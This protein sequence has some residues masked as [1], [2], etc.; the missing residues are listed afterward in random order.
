MCYLLTATTPVKTSPESPTAVERPRTNTGSGQNPPTKV[1]SIWLEFYRMFFHTVFSR[2]KRVLNVMII[3]HWLLQLFDSIFFFYWFWTAVVWM[4]C[5]YVQNIYLQ[6]NI[7]SCV[8][9]YFC[10]ILGNMIYYLLRR[11]YSSLCCVLLTV[12][13]LLRSCY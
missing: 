9:F 8:L 10:R 6:P 4:R 13:H 5:I 7:L 1:I 2:S 12:Q 3:N 11:S